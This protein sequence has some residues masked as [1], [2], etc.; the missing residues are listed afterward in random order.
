MYNICDTR[1]NKQTVTNS[2]NHSTAHKYNGNHHS[3]LTLASGNIKKYVVRSAIM[4]EYVDHI[5]SPP[6][7]S[8]IKQVLNS[9]ACLTRSLDLRPLVQMVNSSSNSGHS[10]VPANPHANL[11]LDLTPTG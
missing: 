10:E 7:H 2:K 6:R 11:K 8:D 4:W 5:I 3:P 1:R 9:A